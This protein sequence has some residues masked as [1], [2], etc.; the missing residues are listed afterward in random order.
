MLF[1]IR[2]IQPELSTQ[3]VV[4]GRD[5]EVLCWVVDKKVN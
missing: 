5:Q 3:I 1:Q 4:D 2:N